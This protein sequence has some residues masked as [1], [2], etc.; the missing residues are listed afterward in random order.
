M[1]SITIASFIVKAK[2]IMIIIFIT[3]LLII[4]TISV[5]LWL[6][7]P[8]KP[9][10][11]I[12]ANGKPLPGS[13]SEKIFINVDGSKQGMIIK[14]R[15][16]TKP[17]LL[18]LHGGIPVYFL[19]S[20]YPTG[21]ENDFVVVWWE[22]RGIG[23]SYQPGIPTESISPELLVSDVITVTN[24]LRQRFGKEKIYLMAHSGGTFLG[25]QAA[26][27]SP[28]LYHAY[29]GVAQMSNQLKSEILAYDYML[30]RFR[31]NGNK[32]MVQKLEAAPVTVAGGTPKQYLGLRDEGMHTLGIGTMHNMHSVITGL[33]LPSLQF[34]EYSLKEKVN[35]WRSK[36]NSGVSIIWSSIITT[37]LS[38]EISE[39]NIPVYFFEGIYDYTCSYSEAKSYFER[40]NAPVKGFYTFQNSAHSPMLEEPKKAQRILQED[41][42]AGL[43]NLA[44]KK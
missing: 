40:L 5:L 23:L 42:L 41:V 35:L 33:F 21:L 34:R 16:V 12:D 2:R 11:F 30:A 8:G 44:D 28:H 36:A 15:D 38:S 31:E 18:F 25:V 9:K 29:I 3:L 4:L 13:I 7:S 22:Q 19:T 39:I 1:T 37:D 6:W 26:A 17:V 32:R 10:P 14:G 20:K 27:K 43:T 24:Y